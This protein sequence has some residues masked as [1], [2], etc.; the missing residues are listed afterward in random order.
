MGISFSAHRC[1]ASA[2]SSGFRGC[3]NHRAGPPILY[4][5]LGASGTFSRTN[6]S[7]PAKGW[8]VPIRI[9]AEDIILPLLRQIAANFP[10][11]S[12]P[13]RNYQVPAAQVVLQIRHDLLESGDVHG[14]LP[15]PLDPVDQVAGADPLPLGFAVPHEVNVGDHR[16]VR[17]DKA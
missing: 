17:V 13:H 15:I 6:S 8:D 4:H 7:R 10:N 5:V 2:S 9:V 3:T 11:I 12:R 16:L 14:P 1:D